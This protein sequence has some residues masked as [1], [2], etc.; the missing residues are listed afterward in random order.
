MIVAAKHLDNA[1]LRRP[2]FGCRSA[3]PAPLLFA[4]PL[5]HGASIEPL[6]LV[7]AIAAFEPPLRRPVERPAQRP[8]GL[9]KLSDAL[10]LRR[11]CVGFLPSLSA[12]PAPTRLLAVAVVVVL[13]RIVVAVLRRED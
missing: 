8:V 4:P 10:L 9:P 13:V 2:P 5:V 6:R 1:S 3:M 11:A 12:S 7:G